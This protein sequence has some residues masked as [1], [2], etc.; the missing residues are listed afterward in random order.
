MGLPSWLIF[1]E[2]QFPS[3]NSVL[4]N[5]AEPILIDTG[6]GSD[7]E[8]T[9]RRVEAA[10][11]GAESL[12]LILNTHYHSDHVGGNHV[13]QGRYGIPVAAHPWEGELVNTKD[14]EAC[15][16]VW[17]DQPVEPYRVDRYLGDGDAI[18]SRDVTI[19]VIHT[20]GHTLGHLSFYIENEEILICGDAVHGDDVCWLNLFREGVGALTRATES[21]QKLQKM[22]VRWA[23]SGHGSAITEPQVVFRNALKRFES[24]RE[25][26]EKVAWHGMKRIFAYLLMIR[27]GLGEDEVTPYLV[28]CPWFIDYSRFTFRTEPAEFVQPFLDEMMRS[29]AARWS[30]G[31]LVATAPYTQPTTDWPGRNSYPPKW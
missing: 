10:G 18:A 9:I 6:F 29:G 2:R 8:E 25:N 7:I 19:R 12:S 26:P 13:L 28:R 22:P 14:G 24:W 16:S 20:P 15:A 5:T 30:D 1:I 17:L 11:V 23:C 21:V 31:R 27:D 4:I 3:A